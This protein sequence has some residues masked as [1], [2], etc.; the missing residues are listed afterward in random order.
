MQQ[1]LSLLKPTRETIVQA[2]PPFLMAVGI[3][4]AMIQIV[5][6]DWLAVLL[7]L[8]GLVF[9]IW[10]GKLSAGRGEVIKTTV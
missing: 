4:Y 2:S 8:P 9:F 6:R 10:R 3:I 1:M 7:V 5:R